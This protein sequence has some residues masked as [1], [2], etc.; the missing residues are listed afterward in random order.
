MNNENSNEIE[1][2]RN[3]L[4]FEKGIKAIRIKQRLNLLVKIEC[5]LNHLKQKENESEPNETN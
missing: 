2:L 5:T 1:Y 4:K 3:L